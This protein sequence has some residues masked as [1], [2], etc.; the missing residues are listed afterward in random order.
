MQLYCRA[1]RGDHLYS[2]WIGLI[3]DGLWG[4]NICPSLLEQERRSDAV[5]YVESSR[6]VVPGNAVNLRFGDDHADRARGRTSAG[7]ASFSHLNVH[8]LD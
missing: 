4:Y 1:A 7:T 2:A 8:E 5:D 3:Y 6:L